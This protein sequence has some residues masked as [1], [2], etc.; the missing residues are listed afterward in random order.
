MVSVSCRYVVGTVFLMA[1][2][3]KI[4]N[5]REF[6]NQVL[7][8]SNFPHL[9]ASLIPNAQLSFRIAQLVVVVLPWLELTCGLCLIFKWAVKETT[10]IAALLLSLFIVQTI[11]NPAEDCHCFF[12]PKAVSSLPAWSHVLRYG[13]LLICSLYLI[14][15]G[16]PKNAEA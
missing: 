5:L 7:L 9:L 10:A 11:V 12:L 15:R 8:H 1:G 3:S 2:V 13:V 4:V 6:E 14:F 16:V